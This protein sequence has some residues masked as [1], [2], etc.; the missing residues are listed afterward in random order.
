MSNK[1]KD[2]AMY[3]YQIIDEKKVLEFMFEYNITQKEL[4]RIAGIQ[5]KTLYNFI[6]CKCRPKFRIQ[7]AL[8]NAM[9]E[10]R[11][12]L[13]KQNTKKSPR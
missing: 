7:S 10:I 13:R 9:K 11:R 1:N 12:E 8:Y 6:Y 5:R 3:Q 2:F 4:A